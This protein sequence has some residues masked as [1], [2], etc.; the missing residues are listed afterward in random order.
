M[1]ILFMDDDMMTK[2]V[3]G[4]MLESLGYE[5]EFVSDGTEAVSSC[6]KRKESGNPFDAVVLDIIIPDGIGGIDTV[7]E[8]LKIDPGARVIASTGFSKESIVANHKEYGFV[9]IIEKPFSTK[10]LKSVLDQTLKHN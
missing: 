1:T 4:E 6:K 5:V 3:A 8:I 10:D 7:N 9:N 2:R